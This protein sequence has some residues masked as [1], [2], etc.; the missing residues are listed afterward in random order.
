[1]IE[2]VDGI[3]I[4]E[5]P[6]KDTSKIIEVFTKKYGVISII[7]KGAKR[8][9]SPLFTGTT[10]L[11]Y[12]SFC[13][14]KKNVSTLRSVDV[15]CSFKNI[16]KDIKNLAA[17]SYLIGLSVQVYK[18]SNEQDIFGILVSSLGKIN[19]F[20]NPLGIVN[21]VEMK[22]LKYLGVEPNLDRCTVCGSC[23][24]A[25]LSIDHGGFLCS[26]CSEVRMNS[27]LLKLIKAYYCVDIIKIDK[28]DV[29]KE[30]MLELDRFISEYY[31]KHTGVFLNQ[32]K[33]FLDMYKG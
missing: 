18:Q 25:S 31:E 9:K 26:N 30:I 27:K 15:I 24:I 20:I 21:I 23:D 13:I 19:E 4:K 17:A 5:T 7:A 28:L 3:V 14:S 6:Y 29:N 10:Y 1:M 2:K 16:L 32:K 8:I 22:Y 12:S 11:S 33:F